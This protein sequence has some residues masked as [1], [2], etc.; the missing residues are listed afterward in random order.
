MD[1]I[2]VTRETNN[3]GYGRNLS[4]LLS[5]EP[6]S[7]TVTT[8][9]NFELSGTGIPGQPVHITVDHQGFG[10]Y[11]TDAVPNSQSE[12]FARVPLAGGQ[13]DVA[14]F[15]DGDDPGTDP[16]DPTYDAET[17][18]I[19][20]DRGGQILNTLTR[21]LTETYSAGEYSHTFDVNADEADEIYDIGILII[22]RPTD[23]SPLSGTLNYI[24]TAPDGAKAE[25][26][27][28][29][30]DNNINLNTANA[31]G[32]QG[33]IGASPSGV[34]TL[35]LD[36]PPSSDIF[37]NMQLYI[38]VRDHYI[39][40]SYEKFHGFNIDLSYGQTAVFTFDVPEPGGDIS[41]LSIGGNIA[42]EAQDDDVRMR[43]RAPDGTVITFRP[44]ESTGFQSNNTNFYFKHDTENSPL[45]QLL[46]MEAIGTW[47]LYVDNRWNSG[48]IHF[49]SMKLHTA[50]YIPD[51]AR[52]VVSVQGHVHS[53]DLNAFYIEDVASID[54]NT[55]GKVGTTAIRV[56]ASDGTGT[57]PYLD[58]T[59]R[60]PD[61][62]YGSCLIRADGTTYSET[63]CTGLD[64]LR[65]SVVK[66]LWDVRMQADNPTTVTDVTLKVTTSEAVAPPF[67]TTAQPIE[68]QP[69]ETQPIETQPIGT[70]PLPPPSNDPG[71][72]I[73]ITTITMVYDGGQWRDF[74]N[75]MTISN[76]KPRFQG[77]ISNDGD[78]YVLVTIDGTPVGGDRTDTNGDF[79]KGWKNA[80]LDSG[81]HTLRVLD[82]Q[83]NIRYTTTFTIR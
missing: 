37:T 64:N 61:G 83:G 8:D 56:A 44:Y 34:W 70:Q 23:K 41:S 59:L 3:D 51:H 81:E 69:I 48:K 28:T 66:G 55:T 35:A 9:D 16:R 17:F 39:T 76:D 5:P 77:S 60:S 32:L 40:W 29:E 45:S 10:T 52:H 30:A 42:G 20:R 58:V 82:K 7:S 6:G 19:H 24:L 13:N 33:L 71:E 57:P 54:V 53:P 50:T 63:N 2:W 4:T 67:Y 79:R 72:V 78:G 1:V 26:Y 73:G 21:G 12:W 49:P 74:E 36:G 68:T 31:P 11:V 14:V 15:L 27:L 22:A 46:G 38:G 65:R 80:A 43:L 18:N 75:G 47:T 25:L 62:A